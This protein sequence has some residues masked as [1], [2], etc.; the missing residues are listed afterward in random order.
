M[1]LSSK[2]N[3]LFV[4]GNDPLSG[5]SRD[6]SEKSTSNI[7]RAAVVLKEASSC[8]ADVPKARYMG[9]WPA[10]LHAWWA[11]L[12]ISFSLMFLH[13]W[14]DSTKSRKMHF[15]INFFKSWIESA[16]KDLPI[17][18]A[19]KSLTEYEQ[20]TTL[21]DCHRLFPE[22]SRHSSTEPTAATLQQWL[23][24]K[25][26]AFSTPLSSTT[27]CTKTLIKL[28]HTVAE[29]PHMLL[30]NVSIS[31]IMSP[32]YQANRSPKRTK[33]GE[34]KQGKLILKYYGD[35]IIPHPYYM[36]PRGIT[37]YFADSAA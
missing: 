9:W 31:R 36:S 34:V 4:V 19:S 10:G 5:I 15:L 16:H 6:G 14:S 37:K 22:I 30:A 35:A 7:S 20:G 25:Y 29:W 13:R 26:E 17:F 12:W 33:S 28:M 24:N 8:C 21:T 32:Q 18:W 2:N 23:M 27:L 3:H 11:V 1:T